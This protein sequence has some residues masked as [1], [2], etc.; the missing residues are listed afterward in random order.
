MPKNN[1]D[2][3]CLKCVRFALWY[4]R[5]EFH[6]SFYGRVVDE[7]PRF[8]CCEN[9]LSYEEYRMSFNYDVVT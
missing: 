7:D 8:F 4:H 2:V 5:R 1:H 3:C 9:F 6:C